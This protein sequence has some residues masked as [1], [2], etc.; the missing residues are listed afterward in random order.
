MWGSC[1]IIKFVN[2]DK[3]ATFTGEYN[4]IKKIKMKTK[5]MILGL[6]LLCMTMSCGKEEPFVRPQTVDEPAK[7]AEDPKKDEPNTGDKP[8]DSKDNGDAGS[9]S[10]DNG[11]STD[12]GEKSDEGADKSHNGA[13]D[14]KQEDAPTPQPASLEEAELLTYFGIDRG[15]SVAQAVELLGLLRAEKTISGK[16]IKIETAEVL[17]RDEEAG[18]LSLRVRGL[19]DKQPLEQPFELSG[20][21]KRPSAY[22][23]GSRMQARWKVPAERYLDYIDLDLLYLEGD[24]SRFTAKFLAE[25]VQFYATTFEGKPYYLTA[26]EVSQMDILE[27]RYRGES[28]EFKTRYNGATSQSRLSLGL[29]RRAYYDRKVKVN[30]NSA[31]LWYLYGVVEDDN[32]ALFLGDF[33]E[34]DSNK[35]AAIHLRTVADASSNAASVEFRLV[36]RKDERELAV[37]QKTVRGFKPLSDLSSDL[38]LSADYDLVEYFRTRF[39]TLEGEQLKQRV[40]ASLNTW[41]KKAGVYYTKGHQSLEWVMMDVDGGSVSGLSGRDGSRARMH[42]YFKNPRFEVVSVERT[43]RRINIKLELTFVNDV[44]L[45]G[46]FYMLSV[47]I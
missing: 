30:S 10:E 20:F 37:L 35:Y 38:M 41:I 16:V 8:S 42:L 43:D 14:K 15:Q 45:D 26:E 22:T 47:P 13:D 11:R 33:L 31:K 12:G 36:S 25:V 21:L 27:L 24:A 2:K 6:A 18:T 4:R 17:A 44:A 19:V 32:M 46:V 39:K 34:Y 40:T 3:G 9:G 28:L 1:Y 23:I 7:P 5:Q 29:D